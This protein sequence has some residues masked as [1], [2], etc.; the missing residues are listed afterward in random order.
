[1]HP[2]V[3]Q[4]QAEP[5]IAWSSCT[6]EFQVDAVMCIGWPFTDTHARLFREQMMYNDLLACCLVTRIHGYYLD[7]SSS[8]VLAAQDPTLLRTSHCVYNERAPSA[9]VQR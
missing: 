1:M 9:I 2:L 3:T 7:C 5:N 6:A 8:N 4:K